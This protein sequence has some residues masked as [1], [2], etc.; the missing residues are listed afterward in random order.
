MKAKKQGL[1]GEITRSFRKHKVFGTVYAVESDDTGTVLAAAVVTEATACRHS[2]A[3][4]E[5]ALDEVKRLN[6]DHRD[7]EFL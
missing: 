6:D 4:I 7:Y 2:L 3:G 5:L 1:T